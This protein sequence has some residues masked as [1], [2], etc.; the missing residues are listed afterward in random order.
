MTPVSI[1]GN[2]NADIVARPVAA[3]PAPGTEQAVDSI[4]FRVGGAG[5]IAALCLAGLGIHAELLGCVGNDPLGRVLLDELAREGVPVDGVAACG[6]TGICVATEAAGRD[7][8]FLIA[9]GSVREFTL[10]QVPDRALGS[11]LVLVCGYFL[12]PA[13]RG[14][15][16]ARLLKE[17]RARGGETL[18]DTGWD[19]DGWPAAAKNEVLD[20]L[21][22]VSVFAPNESEA[23][24]ITGEA[25]VERA[26]RT[27]QERSGGWC[28][29]KRGSQGSM[30]VGP[31]QAEFA[32]AAPE[33][34]VLDTTGAGDA[35]NAGIVRA[36]L[37]ELS[38]QDAVR[39]ATLLAST[40][41]SRPSHDRYP[42][43]DEL[44]GDGGRAKPGRR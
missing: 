5:A 23:L 1:I 8:S 26:A 18:L 12:I 15:G 39:F 3:L 13:L 19:P 30:A 24:A 35:F 29:V 33:V 44:T 17:V 31:D 2:I 10:S 20:L 43:L 34:D 38:W 16:A 9:P 25:S 41:V 22:L 28:I 27:L 37:D 14:G 21:P 42:R 36:R 11:R 6:A 32:I 7:R 40:V 4:E